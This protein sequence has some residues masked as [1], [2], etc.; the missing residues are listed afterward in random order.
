[1]AEYYGYKSRSENALDFAGMA[2]ELAGAFESVKDKREARRVENE[3]LKTDTEKLISK[4][5]LGVNVTINDLVLTGAADGREKLY[6]W[7]NQLKSGEL[8]PADY[9][10]RVNSLRDSWEVLAFS[11]KNL[12]E[13]LL[14]ALERQ[15]PGEDGSPALASSM[16]MY[17]TEDFAKTKN[18][19]NKRLHIDDQGRVF[20]ASMS[21]DG[22]IDPNDLQDVK[23]MAN[24]DNLVDNR[25]NL[26]TAVKDGVANWGE[27]KTWQDL[28]YGK[29]TTE[30]DARNNPMFKEA[31]YDLIESIVS[32][33]N[34]RSVVSILLDNSNEGYKLYKSNE[35]KDKIISDALKRQEGIKGEALTED[36][37]NQTV[38]DTEKK[39]IQIKQ[40]S[41]GTY[42]PVITPQAIEDARRVVETQIEMQLGFSKTGTTKDRP[43][44][45]SGGGGSTKDTSK[46]DQ[47]KREMVAG[48]KASLKAFGLDPESVKANPNDESSWN[49]S[50]ADFGGLRG[51]FKYIKKGNTVEVKNAAGTETLFTAGSPKELA[52]YIYGGQ[53]AA[54]AQLSWEDAR[55]MYLNRG[56][57]QP[58][59]AVSDLPAA[60]MEEWLANGWT[61]AQV[62]EAVKQN[63]IKLN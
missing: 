53:N 43:V 18:V 31:K 36:E 39:L 7:H 4:D 28:G 10:S 33:D 46:D 9:R 20:I 11:A 38:T 35:D 42:N 41:D 29:T 32:E 16:E 19:S 61:E 62:R 24:I 54:A 22:K 21:S 27:V 26:N 51:G 55:K 37:I 59:E 8:K 49:Y 25:I 40:G 1:M 47:K 44:S 48:Y 58:E 14:A 56:Q 45:S 60:T 57:S 6:N 50:E 5:D 13:R 30:I 15:N 2:K 17:M 3:K 34:P 63:K 12:D 52:Q 23:T